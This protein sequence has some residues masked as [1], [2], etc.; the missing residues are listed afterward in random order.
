MKK[1]NIYPILQAIFA[2]ILFGA[3]APISKLLLGDIEPI[4]MAAFLYLGSGLGLLIFR[5]VQRLNR[6]YIR[7]EAKITKNDTKWLIGAIMAGGVIAP[8]ILMFS[9]RNTPA[10]TASLL[11]NFEGV[12]TTI[13][14]ALAFKEAVGRRIWLAVA[15]IAAASILL[16]WNFNGE[17]GFS[18]G[19]S[20]VVLACILWGIDNNFTRNISAKD[21]LIIVTIKGIG[22]GTFS[23]LLAFI[24]QSSFPSIKTALGAMLLGCFSYGVSIVLFILAMRSLG[25]SRT[26]AFFGTAP[27]VGAVL[28]FLLFH[29]LPN[30]LFYISLPIMII[31]AI[32]ILG[33][34]HGHI[35]LHISLE[36]EHR[37]SHDDGHHAHGHDAGENAEH[38]H[39]HEHEHIEHTH[40]HTPDLHHR[41][42]H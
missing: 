31:G 7:T 12:A 40:S 23:L 32:L 36:H 2:A 9:L 25:A 1:T 6:N 39:P 18:I 14:A 26:S 42:K 41:H 34:E 15:A 16:S 3:S 24:T 22:A 20:G 17:W 28:S 29:E 4:P 33:E 5:M 19:A 11:L 27:F 10:S 21:P 30:I 38:S 13:I 37:H 8:I 35:H